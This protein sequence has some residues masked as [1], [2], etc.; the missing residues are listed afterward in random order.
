MKSKNDTIA[1]L[2]SGRGG[3]IALIRVS[4][5]DSITVG[6]KIFHGIH[7]KTL[8]DTKSFTI[9]YGTICDGERTIDEVLISVFRAPHSY[10]G[11][12]MIEISCHAS[13]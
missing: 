3:A 11:E 13:P 4:G 12:N 8:A 6:D 10:T 2:A 1:A 5:N 7:G 9:R